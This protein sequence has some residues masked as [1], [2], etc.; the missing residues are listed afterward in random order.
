MLAGLASGTIRLIRDDKTRGRA[1]NAPEPV[2]PTTRFC[3][4]CPCRHLEM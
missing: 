2:S 3:P 1:H 4:Q